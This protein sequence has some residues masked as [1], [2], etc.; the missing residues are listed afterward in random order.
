MSDEIVMHVE[1][2]CAT[3]VNVTVGL[4]PVGKNLECRHNSAVG[5]V[6]ERYHAEESIA[7]LDGFK[8]VC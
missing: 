3:D 5:R 7:T 1:V 2:N 4:E 6:F 8:D